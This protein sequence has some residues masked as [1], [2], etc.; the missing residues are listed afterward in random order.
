MKTPEMKHT[1]IFLAAL[2]LAPLAA[3][4]AADIPVKPF[5]FWSAEPVLPGETA[6]LQGAGFGKDAKIEL[7]PL[8]STEKATPVAV[9]DANQRSLRF[10]VP[11]DWAAGAYRCRVETKSGAVE[12]LINAPQPWW[13]QAD[14]GRRA[15]PGGWVRV[16][17]RC[18]AFDP[19]KAVVQLRRDGQTWE[20]PLSETSMWSLDA[21]VPKDLAPGDYE[22]W[23]HN[24]SGDEAGWVH[25]DRLKIA[26][27]NRPWL[28]RVFD[29]T[30]MGATSDDDTDDSAALQ[31]ALDEVAAK[32]GGVVSFPRG[33]FRLTGGF[34]LPKNVVLRGAGMALTHLVWADTETPPDAFFASS[35]GGLGIEDLSLYAL[36]YRV[37]VSVKAL[38]DA[39]PAKNV[40]IRRVRA[41]F[42]ALSVKSLTPEAIRQRLEA[43]R[44][45]AVFEIF[46][47]NVQIIDCDLAWTKNIGFAAQG[48]DIVCRG[49][50]A[51]ADEG[52]WCPVGGGRRAIVQRNDFNGVTTGIT[53]GAEVFFAQN[54]IAHVYHGFREGFTTDGA[55]GGPGLLKDAK[56]TGHEIR[57]AGASGRTDA[58]HIPAFVRVIAGAGAGQWRRVE[59]FE[60]D[61]LI[62][63]R[64]FD[65]PVDAGS[66]FYA[67]NAMTRHIL[68]DNDWSDSGIAAQ[69]Y[70]G[71]LDCVMAGNRSAR[72][73]GFRAWGNET[74]WYV[75]MLGN[76]IT[77]GY[78]TAGP[79]ANAGVSAL[80]VVGPYL[81]RNGIRF[82][83]TTARGIVMR[84]NYLDN[85]A[86]IVL[87]A[88]IHDV[89][90]ENNT[91]R[92]SANGIVGD[93]WQRQSGVLLRG[94]TFEDVTTHYD[95]MEAGYLKIEDK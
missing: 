73:G 20:L 61:R 26:A 78:G 90:I 5:V 95:P 28:E 56:V 76:R 79:E 27:A 74:T 45:A 75:Q 53:R 37:G 70:G 93:L 80:H 12:R 87:R 91:I 88:A 9:L 10:V 34:D 17:G 84:G 23:T 47:D 81:T 58:P 4:D 77:E 30:E 6:M 36:N 67:A 43:L 11:K 83:G 15:T 33:R 51:Q 57:H 40:C 89:L 7:T 46:A 49:N 38:K 21:G 25:V 92:H 31:K 22:L 63:D 13:F 2:L 54:R 8:G 16:C 60:R 64:P 71:A 39:A 52:G 82:T 29:V 35:E 59:R 42:T 66:Q 86:S 1:L 72:S 85:N 3:S 24:G 14:D 48:H 41:R 94:N 62:M 50:Q 69:F 68:F 19:A 44:R 18:L 55:F 65:V 32:G